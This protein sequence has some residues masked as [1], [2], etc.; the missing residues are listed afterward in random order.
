MTF[1]G[2]VVSP[3]PLITCEGKIKKEQPLVWLLASP[4]LGPVFWVKGYGNT[5]V[6]VKTCSGGGYCLV[7]MVMCSPAVE[8]EAIKLMFASPTLKPP[9]PTS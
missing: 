7:V 5:L 2:V 3:C 9:H 1:C 4:L 6:D 8:T